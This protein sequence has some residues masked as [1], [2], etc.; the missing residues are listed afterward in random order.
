MKLFE[1]KAHFLQQISGEY[2]CE[3]ANSFFSLLA[4][5]YLK[6]SRLEVSLEREMEVSE[7]IQNQFE[8]ASYRLL[9]HEPI[10]HIIGFTEFFGLDFKVN[11]SVLIPRPETEELVQW[12]LDEVAAK[13]N[14]KILDIGTGSGCIAV[15]LAKNLQEAQ[16]S[17]IDISEKALETA[18]LN[19]LANGVEI[20]FLQTDILAAESLPQQYD[21]IISNPPYVRNLEKAEMQANVLN[22][23]PATA[24]FVEDEAPLIFYDKITQIA[25]EHLLPGGKLFFEINQYLGPQTE[26]LLQDYGFKTE[27]KKDIFGN[28]RMLKGEL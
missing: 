9:Q 21:I 22:Y 6:M 1:L 23:D 11:P 19:A 26:K 2:P 24:L 4:E 16:V 27:L 28:F 18:K 17:A 12:V 8:A 10:Q 5:A 3:E 15:S 7:E 13:Q 20:N 25:K 14:L